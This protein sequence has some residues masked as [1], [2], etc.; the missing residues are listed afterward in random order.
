MTIKSWQSPLAVHGL[1]RRFFGCVVPE[2]PL[3]IELVNRPPTYAFPGVLVI[4]TVPGV[5]KTN[6]GYGFSL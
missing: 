4:T 1:E 2:R 6:P 5:A 3:P